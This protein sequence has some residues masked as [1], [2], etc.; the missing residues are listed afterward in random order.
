MYIII[1]DHLYYLQQQLSQIESL[2]SFGSDTILQDFIVDFTPDEYSLFKFCW[3]PDQFTDNDPI[4]YKLV[5]VESSVPGLER[6]LS[7]SR[8]PAYKVSLDGED[9][10]NI[11]SYIEKFRDAYN[12]IQTNQEPDISGLPTW[13]T[14]VILHW[15]YSY[16]KV[17]TLDKFLQLT[18]DDN[19][20]RQFTYV[21]I[22][23]QLSYFV[24]DQ[25]LVSLP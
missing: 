11:E 15:Q 25:K 7:C 19:L 16:Q 12:A 18:L 6:R 13:M 21:S 4:N 17:Y 5:R 8:F 14:C 10:L 1:L 20:S 2:R 23:Q 9:L 24:E 22:K 3:Y